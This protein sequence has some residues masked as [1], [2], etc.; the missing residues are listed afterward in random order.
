MCYLN[1]ISDT[2]PYVKV[3]KWVNVLWGGA[4]AAHMFRLA[5]KIEYYIQGLLKNYYEYTSI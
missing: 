3:D 4:N 5:Y 2:Q 1:I